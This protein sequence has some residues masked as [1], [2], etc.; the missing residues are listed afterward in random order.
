MLSLKLTSSLSF[1]YQERGYLGQKV[2]LFVDKLLDHWK[3]YKLA[4]MQKRKVMTVQKIIMHIKIE[5]NN[6]VMA[7]KHMLKRC[8][9]QLIIYMLWVHIM[10]PNVIG[11][12][13]LNVNL[14]SMAQIHPLKKVLVLCG[15][16]GH[17]ASSFTFKGNDQVMHIM[18]NLATNQVNYIN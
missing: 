11:L 18:F 2:C 1:S 17:F 15:K 14:R 10:V 6:R 9:Q 7:S 8:M 3:D 12:S 13:P 16:I 4:L 5:N